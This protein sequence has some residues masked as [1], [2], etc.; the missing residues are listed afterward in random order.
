[1]IFCFG[2]ANLLP[3]S[4]SEQETRTFRWTTTL[5]LNNASCAIGLDLKELYNYNTVTN[6]ELENL[7]SKN[8]IALVFLKIK[9]RW[10][11]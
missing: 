10:N 5:N 1:L 11:I 2:I 7:I 3:F 8:D 4:T 6:N 9:I